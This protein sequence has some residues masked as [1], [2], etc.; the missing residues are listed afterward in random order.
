M[1]ALHKR[2][3][4]GLLTAAL[5][6]AVALAGLAAAAAPA[7]AIE[8]VRAVFFQEFDREVYEVDQGE[9]VTFVNADPFLKHGVVHDPM[10]PGD[11]LFSAPVIARGQKRLL[12]GAPY[13]PAGTYE[14]LSPGREKMTAVLEVGPE[15]TPLPPDA[16]APKAGLRIRAATTRPLTRAGRLK[17][18]VGVGEPVE[19]T[20]I[21]RMQGIKLAVRRA[22]ILRPGRRS[23]QLNIPSKV[24][25][26]LRRALVAAHGRGKRRFRLAVNAKLVDAAGNSKTRRVSRRVALVPPPQ[27]RGRG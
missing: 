1:S 22:L 23:F 12:R 14:F 15:G 19:L 16:E 20:L 6:L 13:L 21:A 26:R 4:R 9:L 24:S 11:P 18:R 7:S 25:K 2:R 27:Q 17:V 10:G 3:S 5:A 8:R